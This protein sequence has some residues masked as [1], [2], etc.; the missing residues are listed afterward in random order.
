MMAEMAGWESRRIDYVLAFSQAPIDSDV[1]PH[2]P[3]DFH[4]DGEDEN[5]TYFLKLTN[6]GDIKSYLGMNVRKYQNGTITTI[7]PAIIDKILNRLGIC[8]EL[9][10]HDTPANVILTKMNMELRVS[11]N[12]TIVQ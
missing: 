11:K 5:E 9:K 10:I 12:G 7:Q 2:L 1:Y 3:P 8:N 6:E 4:V